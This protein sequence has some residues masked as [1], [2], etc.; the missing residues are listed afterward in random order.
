[1][2]IAEAREKRHK[3]DSFV[4]TEINNSSSS[5]AG[6]DL[7]LPAR[8]ETPLLMLDRWR[9]LHDEL[10]DPVSGFDISKV[11]VFYYIGVRE[12]KDCVRLDWVLMICFVVL[13]FFVRSFFVFLFFVFLS[14]FSY[15]LF[16]LGNESGMKI[17]D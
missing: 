2:E 7:R 4:S 12:A 13:R 5:R 3:T 17:L 1:M 16:K 14:F 10:Y 9:K 8:G 15:H 11:C 6:R